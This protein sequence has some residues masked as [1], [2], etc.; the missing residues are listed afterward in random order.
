MATPTLIDLQHLGQPH[1]LAVY[2]IWEPELALVDCGPSSCVD[3]LRSALGRLGVTFGDLRH[4]LLTHVHLDHAGAA[5]ALVAESPELQIHVSQL[6]ARHVV[7]PRRLE[8]SARRLFGADFDRLWGAVTPVPSENVRVLGGRP[9]GLDWFPTP[10]HATHH[11]S[12]LS[13]DGSCFSGDVTGVRIAP[14]SYVAPATP[15]P[16]IDL[17]AYERSLTSI[18]ARAPARLCLPHFGIV[19]DPGAH[20]ERMREGLGRW[21]GWVRDGADEAAFLAAA[22]AELVGLEPTVVRALEAAAPFPPSYVGLKRYWQSR[23]AGP[24]AQPARGRDSRP[25]RTPAAVRRRV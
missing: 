14:A 19:D 9:A 8:R 10:G 18:E 23:G 1:V 16:D 11:A 3:T 4:L 13:P 24:S 2:L 17:A 25:D 7:D 20:L 15:P 12:F 6:G 5:G 22:Q 21:A